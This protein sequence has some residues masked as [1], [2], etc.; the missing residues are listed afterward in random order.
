MW[1]NISDAMYSTNRMVNEITKNSL[2]SIGYAIYS[3]N[4][5]EGKK[6]KQYGKMDMKE[7]F[8]RV[9]KR[10][11]IESNDN[12]NFSFS[13]VVKSNFKTDKP[14]NLV[15]FVQESMGYQFVNAVGG[16]NGITPHFN[17]LSKEAILFK[18]LYSNGTRSVRGLAGVSAGN[19]AVPG[20]GVL[21]RNKSQNDFFTIASA[22]KKN[23]AT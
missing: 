14:K 8:D 6:V 23:E 2:Y 11:N 12:D 17:A 20:V 5:H 19:L 10:L 3:N 9:K 13:R 7:A 1:A 4:V 21:K 22:L 15:I 18:D 16:E